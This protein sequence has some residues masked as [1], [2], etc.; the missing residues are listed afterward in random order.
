MDEDIGI[1]K[2]SEEK[3]AIL[4]RLIDILRRD[5]KLTED[6]GNELKDTI[7]LANLTEEGLNELLSNM[8]T[9]ANVRIGIKTGLKIKKWRKII[10]YLLTAGLSVATIEY[11]VPGSLYTLLLKCVDVFNISKSI[12]ITNKAI[13][14]SISEKISEQISEP[15]VSSVMLSRIGEGAKIAATSAFE[16]AFVVTA[17]I[18]NLCSGA[19]CGI[20]NSLTMDNLNFATDLAVNTVI[21][22][23]GTDLLNNINRFFNGEYDNEIAL[24]IDE[25]KMKTGFDQ[26]IEMIKINIRDSLNDMNTINQEY[27]KDNYIP[28]SKGVDI[29]T[30]K[31]VYKKLEEVIKMIVN[32]GYKLTDII[33]ELSMMGEQETPEKN[34][35]YEKSM[36]E[37][38]G[39]EVVAIWNIST[40]KNT[41][42]RS[43]TFTKQN[44]EKPPK[45]ER[46][47]T[48]PSNSA[49]R[50]ESIKEFNKQF[51]GTKRSFGMLDPYDSSDTEE[52]DV[53][54]EDFSNA[55]EKRDVFIYD[56]LGSSFNKG[57]RELGNIGFQIRKMKL[58]KEKQYEYLELIKSSPQ[59]TIKYIQSRFQDNPRYAEQVEDVADI[60]RED[61]QSM[62]DVAGGKKSRRHRRGKKRRV[63]K[64][65]QKRRRIHRRKTQKGKK[66][67]YTKKRH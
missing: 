64:G 20:A 24:I 26:A 35:M 34:N 17:R 52:D 7:I 66:K 41:L 37:K 65:T 32:R 49:L 3:E 11:F 56:I 28:S 51:E 39:V 31:I 12:G 48:F 38:Y 9:E 6:K 63:V 10:F 22:K 47:Y 8:E 55:S 27:Y 53:L 44:I 43:E 19:V 40:K 29:D 13:M 61:I 5:N 58:P 2:L 67:R 45:L 50:P 62:E 33:S 18:A 42:K 16:L 60:I 30:N 57:R 1:T 21:V 36:V 46:S 59:D 25:N 14:E 54:I 4:D 15:M 23:K